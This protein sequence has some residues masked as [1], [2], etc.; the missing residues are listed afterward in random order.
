MNPRDPYSLSIHI[1][2]AM[3]P[4]EELELFVHLITYCNK[5]GPRVENSAWLNTMQQKRHKEMIET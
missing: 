3:Y 2:W 5:E 1:T 4:R